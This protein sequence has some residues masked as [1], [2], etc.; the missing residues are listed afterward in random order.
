M[1]SGT[2]EVKIVQNIL[3]PKKDKIKF[4]IR[5]H[6]KLSLPVVKMQNAKKNF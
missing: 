6:K 5:L 1:N 4:Y 2:L 3:T